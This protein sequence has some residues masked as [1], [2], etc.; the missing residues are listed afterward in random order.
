MKK[1]LLT[2]LVVLRQLKREGLARARQSIDS[3]DV[4]PLDGLLIRCSIVAIGVPM[5]YIDRRLRK[6]QLP[7]KIV[8]RSKEIVRRVESGDI[9]VAAP[10]IRYF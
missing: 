3:H 7:R 6:Q 10:I 1:E 5:H 9:K 2:E 4:H 8:M